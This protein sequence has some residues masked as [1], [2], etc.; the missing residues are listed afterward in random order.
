MHPITI[1]LIIYVVGFLVCVFIALVMVDQ[2]NVGE[3]LSD[4]AYRWYIAFMVFGPLS[5]VWYIGKFL[6][7]V[8]TTPYVLRS[9][10]RD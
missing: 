3:P 6:W 1:A 9:K 7:W 8:V 10:K 5:L 2:D 4:D